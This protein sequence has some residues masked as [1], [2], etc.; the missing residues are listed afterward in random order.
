MT[1]KLYIHPKTN[2][3]Y[4]DSDLYRDRTAEVSSLCLVVGLSLVLESE[5]IFLHPVTIAESAER[6][7]ALQQGPSRPE[8]IIQQTAGRCQAKSN[9]HVKSNDLPVSKRISRDFVTGYKYCVT[10][11]MHKL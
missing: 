9:D 7:P 8:E 10:Y 2:I 5:N 1:L 3:L 11:R 4:D 6:L